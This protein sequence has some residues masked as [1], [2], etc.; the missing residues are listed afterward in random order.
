MS[1]VVPIVIELG[2]V[3]DADLEALTGGTGVVSD[4]VEEVMRIVR[5]R[6]AKSQEGRTLV[7]IVAVY[8]AISDR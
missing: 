1:Y 2:D 8:T 5:E 7:P 3:A 4:D 6:C